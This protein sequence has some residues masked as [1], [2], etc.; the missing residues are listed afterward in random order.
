MAAPED[1]TA[2]NELRFACMQCGDE[3]AATEFYLSKPKKSNS[4]YRMPCKACR[5]QLRAL[6]H[7]T[8]PRQFVCMTC[9]ERKLARAFHREAGSNGKYAQC[10]KVCTEAGHVI[11]ATTPLEAIKLL[12]AQC[13]PE[14]GSQSATNF[15]RHTNSRTGFHS[16]CKPCASG[17]HTD[18]QVE[19]HEEELEKKHIYS[20]EHKE[21]KRLYDITYRA[22]QGDKLR[23]KKQTYYANDENKAKKRCHD[24]AYRLNHLPEER[25]AKHRRRVRL[26]GGLYEKF[27]DEEIYARDGW[28]CGLCLRKVNK[29]LKHPHLLSASLDHVWPVSLGGSHTRQNVALVHL[30]CNSSKQNRTVTQQQRL[31]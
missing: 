7:P 6:A 2:P 31:F 14:T 17:Y 15:S 20:A 24:A 23:T 1:T 25:A 10:C 28:V 19:H 4:G 5:A 30:R 22:T 27:T 13:G 18:W 12:C 11:T 9:G 26:R 21:E 3:K 29:R 16:L 8:P